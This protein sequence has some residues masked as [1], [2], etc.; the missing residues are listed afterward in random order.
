MANTSAVSAPTYNRSDFDAASARQ[1]R[2][3]KHLAK[4]LDRVG[5]LRKLV[6]RKYKYALSNRFYDP[7]LRAANF[8]LSDAVARLFVPSIGLRFRGYGTLGEF[9]AW[10]LPAFSWADSAGELADV[11]E[12]LAIA[13]S[14]ETVT[15]A[16]EVLDALSI[17]KGVLSLDDRRGRLK[18]A[19]WW[20]RNLRKNSGRAVEA[21]CR[22]QGLTNRK[23]GAYI[24][25]HTLRRWQ[26]QGLRALSTLGRLEAV[27]DRGDVVPLLDCIAGSVSEPV[28]KRTELMV[29]MN[30][31]D[32][33]SLKYGEDMGFMFLTITC[34]SKY[35]ARDVYG[36]ENPAYQNLSPRQGSA[37]LNKLWQR[38]RARFAKHKLCTFGFRVSEPHHDGTPHWHLAIYAPSDQKDQVA[39]ILRSLAMEEDGDEPGADVHR[40]KLVEG[41]RER[42]GLAA[43]MAKYIAKN[44]DGEAVGL[45]YESGKDA[46]PAAAR[47]RAWASV[48][49]LHQF[50]EFGGASVT[51]WRHLRALASQQERLPPATDADAAAFAAL[52]DMAD[53]GDWAEFLQQM[54]G[55]GC[56]RD[57]RPVHPFYKLNEKPGRYGDIVKRIKGLVSRWLVFP[58]ISRS[59]E[60]SIREAAPAALRMRQRSQHRN[61]EPIGA[62]RAVA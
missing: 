27:S 17:P 60:W 7:E 28:N 45:D 38:A 59:L 51:V 35:H 29:R 52:V 56:R 37:Y 24:S 43:Y 14:D 47:V 48:W 22:D 4:Q 30:G 31:V 12:K 62:L 58:A 26:A 20:R 5:C 54:G 50:Q 23:Y 19:A 46:A 10:Y 44:I 8:V 49:G 42:G 9:V 11:A 39:E 33:W 53:A 1:A 2:Q 3:D 15:N 55:P 25:G 57:A 32:E 13:F 21:Y 61:T 16:A 40:F 41:D 34:P 36:R 6:S 18:D